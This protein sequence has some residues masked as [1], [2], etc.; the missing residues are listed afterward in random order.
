MKLIEIENQI[1]IASNIIKGM[2]EN[3]NV[4]LNNSKH[5]DEDFKKTQRISNALYNVKRAIESLK[6]EL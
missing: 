5:G 4:I 3:I 2:D 6:E 1:V